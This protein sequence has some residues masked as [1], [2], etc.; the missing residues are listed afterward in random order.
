MS[1]IKVSM[2]LLA[3]AACCHAQLESVD[4]RVSGLDCASCAESIEKRLKRVRGVDSASL[5]S[6]T[7]TVR[8]ALAADNSVKLDTI[9]DALK[10]LGYTPGDS[11]VV[12]VG[13]ISGD[14]VNLPHQD[15]AFVLDKAEAPGDRV[16]I[17]GTVAAG[18]QKLAAQSVSPKAQ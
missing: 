12:L 2:S 8:I 13:S 16:R 14:R 7:G 6:S 3:L 11:V 5:D 17:K 10:G 4:I 18:T 15:D 9:R 1:W